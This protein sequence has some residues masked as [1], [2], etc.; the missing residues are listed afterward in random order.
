MRKMLQKLKKARIP[1]LLFSIIFLFC[2]L[3]YQASLLTN[4]NTATAQ[5]NSFPFQA[6]VTYDGF[7]PVEIKNT[8]ITDNILIME[9]ANVTIINSTIQGTIYVFNFGI[10]HLLQNSNVTQNVVIS[11]SSTF[12]VDNS[13]IGGLIECHDSSTLELLTSNTQTT[14]IWKFNLANVTISN[15]TIDNINDV[16]TGGQ[17]QITNTTLTNATLYKFSN[18]RVYINN[19]NYQFINDAAGPPNIITGPVQFNIFSLN[20]SYST[21]E[22]QINLTWLGWDSPIIDGFLNITFQILLD[23]LPYGP[24]INGSGFFNQ[25]SGHYLINFT[26]TGFHNISVVSFDASGNNFTTT[27]QVEIIEYPQFPWD[28]FWIIV[29]IIAG[30]ITGAVLY[31]RHQQKRG[32]HSSLGTIFKKELADSKIKL[33]IFTALAVAPGIILFSIFTLLNLLGGSTSIDTIRSLVNIVFTMFLYYFG[34]AFAIMF[35]LPVVKTKRDGSLGWFLSKPVRRWEFLWGKIFAY[36][37]IIVIV[38]IATS[39]AFVLCSITFIDPIYYSDLFSMGGFILLIGLA[40]L[41]PLTAIVVLCSTI[42]NKIGLAIFL[43]IMILMV[44]PPLVSFLPIA[45]QHEWPLLFSLSYYYENLGSIWIYNGG[46][47]F[48]T[49]SSSYGLLLGITITPLELTVTHIALIL[50]GITVVCFTLATIYI[51]RTDIP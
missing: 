5:E 13:T 34:L 18:S 28:I 14:T 6:S 36:L 10:L 37:F 40:A 33:I 48:G 27:I 43:P 24:L 46:G 23:G 11:D 49:I 2:L 50:T 25:Y 44:I 41:V 7:L 19:S 35:G 42:L 51:Q 15:S 26:T 29:A 30:I 9:Y 16:G 45:T 8:T 31:S 1:I 3:Q 38:V 4:P 22:R 17:I 20:T 12:N 39:V 47:L 21:S 32:Y